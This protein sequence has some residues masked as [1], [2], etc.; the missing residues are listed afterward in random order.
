MPESGD[1]SKTYADSGYEH[2]VNTQPAES[3]EY[4]PTREGL[5]F[6]QNTWEEPGKLSYV[7]MQAANGQLTGYYIF[8]ERQRQNRLGARVQ[9]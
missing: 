3:M 4:S 8:E 7:Y 9:T 5:N 2:L 6:F 1:F